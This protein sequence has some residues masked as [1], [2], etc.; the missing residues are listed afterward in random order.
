MKA[1]YLSLFTVIIFSCKPNYSS[2]IGDWVIVDMKYNDDQFLQFITVA[3]IRI[4]LEGGVV[5]GLFDSEFKDEKVNTNDSFVFEEKDGEIYVSIKGSNFFNDEFK[6]SCLD[7][8][9]C[10]ILLENFDKRVRCVYNGA[11]SPFESARGEC[12]K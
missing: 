11:L 7:V 1:L 10:E 8:N 5:P 9:C 12:L 3:N 2:F 4:S 6:I